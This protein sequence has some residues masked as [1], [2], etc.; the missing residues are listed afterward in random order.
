MK[1]VDNKD[2][3][4]EIFTVK[5]THG[6]GWYKDHI[7]EQHKATFCPGK[8]GV[9]EDHYILIEDRYKDERR[10]IYTIDCQVIEE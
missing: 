10:V 9:Y 8:D 1:H 4:K 5:I 2:M 7:G 6:F 3:Y